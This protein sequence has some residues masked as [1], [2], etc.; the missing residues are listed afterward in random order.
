LR[1]LNVKKPA[2]RNA[3][4][5]AESRIITGVADNFGRKK[6]DFASLTRLKPGM[7]CCMKC[8]T[9]LWRHLLA[10]GK[11]K[12][13]DFLSAGLKALKSDRDGEGGWRDWPFTY[14]LSALIEWGTDEARGEL[15]YAAPACE[16]ELKRK[17]V[18]TNTYSQR[19]R[20]VML[21]ALGAC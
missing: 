11:G 12:H 4:E 18:K 16:R 7:F 20:E 15:E 8:S 10:R 21:R 3:M 5:R 6:S 1:L 13:A 2:I 9:A 14:T 17:F 19:R